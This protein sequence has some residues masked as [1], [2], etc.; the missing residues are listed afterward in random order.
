MIH[1]TREPVKFN[2]D[3][4]TNFFLYNRK[5]VGSTMWYDVE[6]LPRMCYVPRCSYTGCSLDDGGTLENR[7]WPE[8]ESYFPSQSL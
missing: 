8:F 7:E 2:V 5:N 1:G 6:T 4:F 3:T